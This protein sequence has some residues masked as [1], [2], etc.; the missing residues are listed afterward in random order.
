[1]YLSSVVAQKGKLK[2]CCKIRHDGHA[3]YVLMFSLGIF[4]NANKICLKLKYTL[5]ISKINIST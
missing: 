3:K 5:R 1:M 2:Y 4:L